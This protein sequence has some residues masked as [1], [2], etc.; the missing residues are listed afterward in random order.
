MMRARA[1]DFW[2][3]DSKNGQSA[4]G[5]NLVGRVM[6]TEGLLELQVAFPIEVVTTEFA[7]A[8]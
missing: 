8:A 4:I 7:E 6:L 3:T 5:P 2:G 1:A